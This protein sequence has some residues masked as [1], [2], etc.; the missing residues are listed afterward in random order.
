[1]TYDTITIEGKRY[2]VIPEEEYRR[3]Q[4]KGKAKKIEDVDEAEQDRVD[5]AESKRRL[6]DPAEKPIPWAQAKQ[7]LNLT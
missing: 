2:V 4:G 1:M 3:Q 7:E 5:A 6:K